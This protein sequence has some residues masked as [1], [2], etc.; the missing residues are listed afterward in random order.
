MAD[1]IYV[2]LSGAIAQSANLEATAANLANSGTDGYQRVRPVFREELSR[3]GVGDPGLH[4]ASLAQTELDP[5]RGSTRSTGR[6]TDFAMAQGTYLAVST[7]AGER[8][9]RASSLTAGLDGIVRTS[10]GDQVA[11]EDGKPIKLTGD[12]SAL[13]VDANG[14]LWQGEEM[15]AR[16][17][18]VEFPS[19]AGLVHDSGTLLAAT[20]TAGTPTPSSKPVEVGT[21]EESNANVVGS[22]TE[23]VDASRTFEAFQ[24][25]IDAFRDADRAAVTTLPSVSQ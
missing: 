12:T 13:R 17:R 25:V 8:Y 18:L 1:G 21:L 4:Y 15:R 14:Q 19:P 10:H 7:A 23:L 2:A 3:A 6:Q 20:P 22:M 11:G 5:T 24:R 16:L 9:T